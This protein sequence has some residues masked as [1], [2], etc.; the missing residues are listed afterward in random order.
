MRTIYH[1]NSILY[2]FTIEI[3]EVDICP[4]CSGAGV[5]DEDTM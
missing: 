3:I 2:Y 1:S 4:N 5:I